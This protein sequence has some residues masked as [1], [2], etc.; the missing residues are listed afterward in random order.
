MLLDPHSVRIDQAYYEHGFDRL[1][2]TIKNLEYSIPACIATLPTLY[3]VGFNRA[4]A[5]EIYA[6]FQT[7]PNVNVDP[8]ISFVEI[9]KDHLYKKCQEIFFQWV[10]PVSTRDALDY[11][12]ISDEA[13]LKLL[14]LKNPRGNQPREFM[15]RHVVLDNVSEWI[16]RYFDCRMG[17]LL[18]LDFEIKQRETGGGRGNDAV[19]VDLDFLADQ[20]EN[21]Y[22]DAEIVY[23]KNYL[24]WLNIPLN[25]ITDLL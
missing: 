11:V 3:F 8:H 18:N 12:G 17:L 16:M 9:A 19:P 22:V 5:S 15:L 2:F 14:T 7:N 6:K 21:K 23:G 13:Q 4:T 20:L 1:T 10:E 24:N 25:L